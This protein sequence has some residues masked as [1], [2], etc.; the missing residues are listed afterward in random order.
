MSKFFFKLQLKFKNRISSMVFEISRV[1]WYQN[2]TFDYVNRG[3]I[4]LRHCKYSN[5]IYTVQ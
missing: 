3:I 5:N 4:F 1:I 2:L